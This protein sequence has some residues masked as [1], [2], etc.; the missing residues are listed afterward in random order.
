MDEAGTLSPG[1]SSS[2]PDDSNEGMNIVGSH[3]VET[4]DTGSKV[5]WADGAPALGEDRSVREALRESEERFRWLVENAGDALFL[6]DVD[7]TIIDVN[8]QACESLG[9][10]PEE[11]L[12]SSLHDIELDFARENIADTWARMAPGVPVTLQ[13]VHRRRDGSTFP[14]EIRLCVLQWHGRPLILAWARDVSERYRLETQLLQAHKMESVGRLASGLAHD[15]GNMLTPILSYSEL[16]SRALDPESKLQGYLQ[17]IQKAAERAADLTHQ[18]LAFSRRQVTEPRA[19]SL[20]D[21]VLDMNNMLRRLMDEDIEQVTLLAPDLGMVR[22]DP[23]QMQQVIVNLVINACHAMPDGGQL[24]I[25]TANVT[26]SKEYARRHPEAK[27]GR[28]VMLTVSDRGIGMTEDVKAHLFEP[29]F[30][31]KETGRGTGLGL[32]TCYG[33]VKQC[34]G[35]ITV[36][37]E[38]GK[39]TTFKIYLPRVE[40]APGSPRSREEASLLPTGN[41]TVLLVEDADAVREAV[42]RVL[43]RQGYTALEAANGHEAL[44]VARNHEGEDIHL[45]LT[46]VVM[47]LMGGRELARELKKTHPETNVLYISGYTEDDL[48]RR[49]VFE[50]GAAFMAKPFTSTALALRV[51]EVLDKQ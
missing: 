20:S 3:R 4:P 31:T 49:G 34:G 16:V 22:V 48:Q 10:S 24:V 12:A 29:F 27:P 45:L 40:D 21:L 47:P 6:Y 44:S 17:E 46:D 35:H 14:V 15:F 2:N 5:G 37:S 39:G 43:R 42:C 30:T 23:G 11:L 8:Q 50:P 13:R 32:S 28:H 1:Q 41:E 38:Q 36:D 9:Y 51:R 19:L 7:G 18:L 33:I 25:E 26:L